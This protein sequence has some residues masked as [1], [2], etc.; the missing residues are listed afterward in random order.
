MKIWSSPKCKKKLFYWWVGNRVKLYLKTSKLNPTNI[1]LLC[2]SSLSWCTAFLEDIPYWKFH[3]HQNFNSVI[4]QNYSLEILNPVYM[5]WILNVAYSCAIKLS[6]G[7][8]FSPNLF[9]TSQ[10]Y[11]QNPNSWRVHTAKRNTY[12]LEKHL[13]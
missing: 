12:C 2:L 4:F 3:P 9:E 10:L 1:N 11:P 5:T 13:V 6:Q 7:P 8:I